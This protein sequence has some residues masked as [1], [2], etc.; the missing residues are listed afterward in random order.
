M[1][2][3]L[4]KVMGVAAFPFDSGLYWHLS[5]TFVLFDFPN[6]NRGYFYPALLAPARYLSDGY[7]ALGYFPF[8]LLSSVT[9]AYF[10]AILI[11]NFYLKIFGGRLSLL[12]RLITPLLITIL[13]PG[14]ITYPLSDL[15]ALALM[16]GASASVLSSASTTL[17]LKRYAL[18]VLAGLLAYGAYNTRTIYLFPAG[19]LTLAI[20]LFIY[21]KDSFGAKT[22]TTLAFLFGAAVASIPQIAINAKNFDSLSPLVQ[23][24]VHRS[25]FVNQLLW[26]ITLQRYETSIDKTVPGPAVFYMD[27]AGE[28][29]FKDNKIGSEPF[30]LSSYIKLVVQNPMAFIGIYGRHIFNG[31]DLRDG[32]VYTIGQPGD[33]D[34]LALFNFFII[35]SGFLIIIVNIAEKHRTLGKTLKTGFWAFLFLLPVIAIIPG[36]IETRFFLSLQ[37]A[38]Y[39]SLAFSCDPSA[40]RKLLSKHWLLIGV[41]LIVSATFFVSVSTST[42]ANQEYNFSDLYRGK[43]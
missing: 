26:G 8:R 24:G 40:L 21:N 41:A 34:G 42:M 9:Y 33:R 35:F 38:I 39:C 4:H 6:T 13:L 12:R 20:S 19:L 31:L 15:P 17:T 2:M 16:V 22:L 14:L 23:T 32:E 36:A 1:F 18:L 27:K 43:W 3:L 11:P 28:Q 10:F 7:V 5:N 25:L 29:L 37:M 30:E